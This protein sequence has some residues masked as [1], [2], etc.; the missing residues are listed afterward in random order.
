MSTTDDDIDQTLNDSDDEIDPQL[1]ADVVIEDGDDEYV[2]KQRRNSQKV[3]FLV[4]RSHCLK[5][6]RFWVQNVWISRY[7]HV[8]LSQDHE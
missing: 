3:S 8:T 2:H 6:T 7:L 1:M 5:V 4:W